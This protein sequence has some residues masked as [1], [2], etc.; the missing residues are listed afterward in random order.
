MSRACLMIPC[1]PRCPCYRQPRHRSPMRARRPVIPLHLTPV[2]R[3]LFV[4]RHP[5]TR[6]LRRLLVPQGTR[7]HTPHPLPARRRALQTQPAP[8]QLLNTRPPVVLMIWSSSLDRNASFRRKVGVCS[9]F[10][11][12]RRCNRVQ[13][14]LTAA[15]APLGRRSAT[16]TGRGSFATCKQ[17]CDHLRVEDE[18]WTAESMKLRL[19]SSSSALFCIHNFVLQ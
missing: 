14:S 19:R 12:W 13:S 7:D 15:R 10:K 16:T 6:L 8:A 17:T 5:P 4:I 3:R 2:H 1:R 18:A 9:L 11:S